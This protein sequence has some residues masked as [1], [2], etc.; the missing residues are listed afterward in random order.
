MFSAIY[1]ISS[2]GWSHMP[3]STVK[4]FISWPLLHPQ[5]TFRNGSAHTSIPSPSLCLSFLLAQPGICSSHTHLMQMPK[6][7]IRE[8]ESRRL[9]LLRK[10]SAASSAGLLKQGVCVCARESFALREKCIWRREEQRM[11][12]KTSILNLFL[13]STACGFLFWERERESQLKEEEFFQT[14]EAVWRG[15]AC[16]ETLGC[17]HTPGEFLFLNPTSFWT[18]WGKFNIWPFFFF[19]LGLVLFL[20]FNLT[21]YVPCSWLLALLLWSDRLFWMKLW[22]WGS[23]ERFTVKASERY[24]ER[25]ETWILIHA[26]LSNVSRQLPL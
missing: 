19:F 13:A 26:N 16:T 18:F 20:F 14:D 12:W 6:L 24:S 11:R 15:L 9:C 5:S 2:W 7:R 25:E 21:F 1:L 3:V 10:L 23:E 17:I 4:S 8:R 22:E